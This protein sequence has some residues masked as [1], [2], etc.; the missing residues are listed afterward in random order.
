MNYKQS[1]T[2]L[3]LLNI[4]ILVVKLIKVATNMSVKFDNIAFP[5]ANVVSEKKF[6]FLFHEAQLHPGNKLSQDL[7]LDWPSFL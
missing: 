4:Y 7:T 3:L 6:F 2:S 1:Y 5:Y